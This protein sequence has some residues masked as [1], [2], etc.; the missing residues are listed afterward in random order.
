L[1]LHIELQVLHILNEQ[2]GRTTRTPGVTKFHIYI[3]I[4]MCEIGNDEI[5]ARDS[6]LD[7]TDAISDSPFGYCL[8]FSTSSRNSRTSAL[9]CSGCSAKT[10]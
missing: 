1:T 5:R 6:L 4:G 2:H 8:F 3:R 7:P 9:N 10:R